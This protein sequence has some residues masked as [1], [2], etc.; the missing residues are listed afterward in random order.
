MQIILTSR[1]VIELLQNYLQPEF[2]YYTSIYNIFL[3]ENSKLNVKL[4]MCLRKEKKISNGSNITHSHIRYKYIH[5]L[6]M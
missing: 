5:T 4:I 6:I 3:I 1:S 2:S